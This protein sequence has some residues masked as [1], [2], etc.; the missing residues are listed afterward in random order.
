MKYL[1]K[2]EANIKG[3]SHDALNHPLKNLSVKLLSITKELG[4]LDGDYKV[5]RYFT[6]YGEIEIDYT[7]SKSFHFGNYNWDMIL[8]NMYMVDISNDNLNFEYEQV[9]IDGTRVYKVIAANA[10]H[11]QY[12]EFLIDN[13][14]SANKD[15]KNVSKNCEDFCDFIDSILK[16]YCMDYVYDVWKNKY[17]IDR[18]DINNIINDLDDYYMYIDSKNFNL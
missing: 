9:Y 4:K 16:K 14:A 8:M 3:S 2:F 7:K 18:R 11:S 6:D 5:K 13:K 10:M 1:K 12:F 17:I 15:T